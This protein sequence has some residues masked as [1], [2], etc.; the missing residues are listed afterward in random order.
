MRS[1]QNAAEEELE[2]RKEAPT[3]GSIQMY[4]L[5][6]LS[7]HQHFKERKKTTNIKKTVN[8]IIHA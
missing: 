1:S 2:K 3:K 4:T 7:R 5:L 8:A 6:V